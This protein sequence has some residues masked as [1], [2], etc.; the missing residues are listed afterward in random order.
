MT[1]TEW[2]QR[3]SD[4][5]DEVMTTTIWLINDWSGGGWPFPPLQ[6]TAPGSHPTNATNFASTEDE[7]ENYE[8]SEDDDKE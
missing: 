3:Q 8:D 5:N 4:D 7:E 2:W 6:M 1:T